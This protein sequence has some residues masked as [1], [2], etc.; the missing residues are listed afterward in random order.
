MLFRSLS[1]INSPGDEITPYLK[2]S[3]TLYFASNGLGGP[4]GFDLYKSIRVDG[5][6]QRPF[7]LTDINTEFDESDLTFINETTCLF[8]SNRPGGKGGL[9]IYQAEIKPNKQ[10]K[11]DETDFNL[12]LFS[13]VH[14]IKIERN[15]ETE[16]YQKSEGSEIIKNAKIDNHFFPETLELQ[17]MTKPEGYFASA[18]LVFYQNDKQILEKIIAKSK[19]EVQVDL[20]SIITPPFDGNTLL[21]IKATAISKAN[22]TIEKDLEIAF[23]NREIINNRPYK[24]D[25]YDYGRIR[26]NI[27]DLSD[28]YYNQIFDILN[29][30]VAKEIIIESA[31]LLNIK[32]NKL[33]LKLKANFKNI[34]LK[35]NKNI[36]PVNNIFIYFR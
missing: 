10:I 1:S 30:E 5:I 15:I 2:S 35:E 8:A 26:L 6:W 16:Y 17:C 4:G 13:T 21:R 12:S 11:I 3:D 19:D 29:F 33:A 32:T 22:F 7:P 20:N 24:I 31:D 36:D 23:S 28:A 34:K 18:K 14:L 9:D 25:N 27:S